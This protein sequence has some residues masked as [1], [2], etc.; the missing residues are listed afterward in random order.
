MAHSIEIRKIPF[1]FAEGVPPI[2][3]P[4]R[5]E[6]SHMVNGAS[7][8]MPHL[9]P[10][11]NRT[12][13]EAQK[14]IDDPQL[15]ADIKG[16][17]GQE[18]QHYTNHRRMNDMLKAQGYPELAAVEESFEADYKRLAK[19][20]LAARLAYCA[21]FETM[22]MGITEWLINDR[23]P[24]FQDADPTVSSLVLW[25]MVEE[26]EHKTVAY[27]VY[28]SVS[29]AYWLRLYGL[30][31]GSFHV[32]F[33]SRRAYRT[34][35]KKDGLW[36]SPASRLRLWKMV[37]RFFLKAGAAMLDSMRPGYHPSNRAD[38]IWID[39]WHH[40]YAGNNE[41]FVPMLDTADDNIAPVV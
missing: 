29:G 5:H 2:W 21:G 12:M 38:P 30:L 9:E 23:G 17:I 27:D 24:L 33:M 3:N 31:H 35:L 39:Q 26:T 16:F 14:H 13:R 25:H 37:G 6:W 28:Q 40:A 18:A 4:A 36:W 19:R 41:G 15:L 10:F 1:E 8:T 20:S 7:L 34:M 32:G 11:L 22:T